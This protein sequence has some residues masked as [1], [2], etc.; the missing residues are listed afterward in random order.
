[1]E[2]LVKTDDRRRA[3]YNIGLVIWRLKCYYEI[4]HMRDAKNPKQRQAEKR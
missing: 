3:A 2:T 1:M 4:P